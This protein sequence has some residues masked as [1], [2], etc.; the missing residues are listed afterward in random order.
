M[1][2][3]SAEAPPERQTPAT[4]Q[5]SLRWLM[6]AT[7]VVA[8]TFGM[9]MWRGVT[10]AG[11]LLLGVLCAAVVRALVRRRKKAA[12]AYGVVALVPIVAMGLDSFGPKSATDYV[13]SL[14]GKSRIQSSVLGIVWQDY[15]RDNHRTLWYKEAG[16]PDHE[17]QWGYLCGTEQPWGGG[18][19][20]SD[21]FGWGTIDKLGA[22]QDIWPYIDTAERAMLSDLY[23][24]VHRE[25]ESPEV[26][27]CEIHRIMCVNGL[28]QDE[29]EAG[30]S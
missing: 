25:N 12:I 20:H 19:I 23:M 13:C 9:L 7:A 29:E 16:F 22:L 1:T 5:F 24:R 26:F 2:P 10:P 15:E 17:H 8:A 3:T 27:W 30:D 4:L 14:C 28:V 11:L 6:A 21:T 18:R